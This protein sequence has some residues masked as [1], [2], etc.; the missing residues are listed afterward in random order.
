MSTGRFGRTALRIAATALAVTGMFG[1]LSAQASAAPAAP[2]AEATVNGMLGGCDWYSPCGEVG[3]NSSWQMRVTTT[4]GT[5]PHFCDV[6]NW[7]GG[8]ASVWKHANC[9]QVVLE[10]N[11]H[12]GGGNVD[13]DAFTFADRNYMLNF[14]GT[15][16]WKTAGVWTKIQNTEG[17]YCR[18]DWNYGVPVC[19]VVWE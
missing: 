11:G 9:T 6:W 1:A 17:A 3:N 13:V 4:L 18:T 2:S 7:N 10:R 12:M 16:S 15:L 8:S 14:H 19:D 5:G